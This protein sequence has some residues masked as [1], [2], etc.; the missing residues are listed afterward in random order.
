MLA[1]NFGVVDNI[2][3]VHLKQFYEE[4]KINYG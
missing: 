2:V 3:I 4:I 1:S